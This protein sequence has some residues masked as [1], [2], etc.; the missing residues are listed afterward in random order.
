[1]AKAKQNLFF[2]ENTYIYSYDR[3]YRIVKAYDWDNKVYYKVYPYGSY[4]FMTFK[5]KSEAKKYVE[6]RL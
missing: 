1:M 5:K 2:E 3:S 6:D 4:N